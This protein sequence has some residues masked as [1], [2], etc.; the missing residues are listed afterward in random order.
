[1]FTGIF[2]VRPFRPLRHDHTG[3]TTISVTWFSITPQPKVC[4]SGP[5]VVIV[6]HRPLAAVHNIFI[7]HIVTTVYYNVQQ[8]VH[9]LHV[10]YSGQVSVPLAAVTGPRSR[11]SARSQSGAHGETRTVGEGPCEQRYH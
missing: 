11:S 8:P 3:L 5:I 9:L 1:M 4:L 2:A 6:Y 7:H 10:V